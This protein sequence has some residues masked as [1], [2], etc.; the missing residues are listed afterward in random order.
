MTQDDALT[1]LKMGKNV[2]LTGAAGS[3]KTH[4]LN[5]YITWL[6]KHGVEPAVTASTGIA[7][8]H[9]GGQTIHS[10]SG[11]GIKKELTAYDI[12]QIEQNEKLVKRFRKTKVLIIDEVSMLSANTLSMV[13]RAIQAGLQ[14]FEPFGGMQVVLSGDFFQLPPISREGENIS[15][16]FEG[17]AWKELGLHPCYLTGQHRQ[18]DRVFLKILDDIRNGSINE[19]QKGKLRT[20]VQV[21]VPDDVPHL[22]TH[23]IDV[24]ALNNER[25]SLLTSKPYL[26][27]ME[28]K[29][30]KARIEAL[31]RGLLVPEQLTLKKGA[32]V[33]FVKNHPQGLYVNGTLGTVIGFSG[34]M[35]KVKTHKGKTFTVEYESWG[36][37]ENGKMLAEVS[38]IPLRLAWAITIHKSQGITLDAAYID[39][40]KTFVEGQGY[41]ALSRVK[42]LDG[43]YLKGVHESAYSRH[44]KVEYADKTFRHA[45]EKL[46]KRI[47]KTEKKR[48]KEL[49]EIFIAALQGN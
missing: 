43:L 37:E 28:S 9:I 14:N 45:S 49:R 5:D 3:G 29:G 31:K 46:V 33:M 40:T 17:Q 32:S 18:D 35:P 6:K 39:L 26:Y 11:I 48:L 42:N 7:A 24:D 27:K 38:Q 13:N 34:K 19:G 25:L 15:F 16:C 22:Y 44:P 12:D 20:H 21:K 2:F 30:S 1:I 47:E 41:V 10:W 23:N 36:I 4:V 8:T